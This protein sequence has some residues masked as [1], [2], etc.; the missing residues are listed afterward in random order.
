MLYLKTDVLILADAFQN[1]RAVMIDVLGLDPANYITLA[2]YAFDVAKKVTKVKLEL[3]HEGQE[4]MHEF[5]QRWM[6]G[7][8]SM[9]PRR[10]AKANFP[11]MK[12]YDKKWVNKWLS[13]YLDANNLYRWAMIQYLP[14]GG[15][16]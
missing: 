1:F 15:F 12:G 14:T 5:V 11:G 3:F 4:D 10:I 8:N 9:V 6:R 2:S 13:M 7:E 16:R